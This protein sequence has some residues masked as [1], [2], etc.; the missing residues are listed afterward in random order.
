MRAV[1]LAGVDEPLRM[2]ERPV[3]T[4]G[5]GEVRVRVQACGVCGSD[6]LIQAGGIPGTAF[7]LVLGHEAAGVVDALGAGVSGVAPGDQVAIY[8]MDGA[9]D[10][11]ARAGRPNLSLPMTRMGV[12][13][14]GAF[15]D[16]VVV[17]SKTLIRPARYVDPA[18]LAV[19]TDAV[20]TPYH[21]LVTV[22][23][24][25]PGE[26]LVVMGIGGIGSN[27]V[28]LG[29]HLGA[30]VV[31][32]SRSASKLALARELGAHEA[33]QTGE[34]DDADRI[35]R[36]VGGRGADVVVQCAG[37]A[38]ADE[39]AVAVAGPAGRVVLVGAAHEPFQVRATDLIW[40]ELAVLGSRA[41]TGEE[42]S[43]CIDLY[44]DGAVKVAHLLDNK[45]PLEEAN[46]ALEDLRA[47]GVLR[48]ILLPEMTARSQ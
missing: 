24:V 12:E 22:G 42:I 18:V 20:A 26:T 10:E 23:R 41:F 35:R 4:P 19:L 25:A 16:Y 11:L 9:D 31:A 14:D 38:D 48:S 40:R 29:R 5:P 6:L 44:L 21:A 33:V 45:R 7:P 17:G 2:V 32:A 47:G 30:R 37:S 43:A 1:E 8:Y 39:L 13:R 46:D 36:V 28:Q 34:P 27:A 3:P 15:A